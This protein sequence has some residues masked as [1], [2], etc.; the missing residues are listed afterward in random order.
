M[1]RERIDGLVYH[2][3]RLF[4]EQLGFRRQT[5]LGPRRSTGARDRISHAPCTNSSA[6]AQLCTCVSAKRSTM[7]PRLDALAED[8]LVA[9]LQCP[10][11]SLI[12]AID[13]A[14]S[15][16]EW[17]TCAHRFYFVAF[18]RSPAGL[19]IGFADDSVCDV[20]ADTLGTDT[21]KDG[22]V[23]E[24]MAGPPLLS[25]ISPRTVAGELVVALLKIVTTIRFHSALS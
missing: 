9:G 21:L 19:P 8:L 13:L 22:F 5:R 20:G 17:R 18:A 16:R 12:V 24:S 4:G 3:A 10:D 11:E 15:R 7:T 23:F 2:L 6:I 14:A 1:R 25:S